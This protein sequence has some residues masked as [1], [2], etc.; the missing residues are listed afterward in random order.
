M[1]DVNLCILV[2]V[3]TYFLGEGSF[4]YLN[5]PVFVMIHLD[6]FKIP[7]SF[8]P[9]FSGRALL[10]P[11]TSVLDFDATSQYNRFYISVAVFL[12]WLRMKIVVW[13]E[14]VG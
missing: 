7:T 6:R 8:R 2:F 13:C 9:A 14:K 5:D 1:P 11:P 10:D 12:P 3:G 4:C